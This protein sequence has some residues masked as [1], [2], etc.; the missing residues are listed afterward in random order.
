MNVPETLEQ[1]LI[2]FLNANKDKNYP[3]NYN[4][5]VDAAAFIADHYF[6]QQ[7][8][9]DEK[10]YYIGELE[11]EMSAMESNGDDVVNDIENDIVALE[12]ELRDMVIPYPKVIQEIVEQMRKHC[13]NWCY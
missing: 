2:Q 3:D 4:D 12:N 8:E 9:L 10:D 7:E 1:Y 13:D 11:E 6:S 5:I